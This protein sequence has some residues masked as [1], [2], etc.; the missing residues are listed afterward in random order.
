MQRQAPRWLMG[1]LV[2]RSSLHHSATTDFVRQESYSLVYKASRQLE[3]GRSPPYAVI[4]PCGI[5]P[6]GIDLSQTLTKFWWKWNFM[7]DAESANDKWQ[8]CRWKSKLE[9]NEVEEMRPYMDLEWKIC[10][11]ATSLILSMICTLEL[12]YAPL[13]VFFLRLWPALEVA[14]GSWWI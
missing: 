5:M 14:K 6:K 12:F 9:S 2:V 10:S 13:I 3:G 1:S 8:S 7:Q 4:C 11:A